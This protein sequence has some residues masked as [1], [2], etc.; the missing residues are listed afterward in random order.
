[1]LIALWVAL[2][3]TLTA[4]AYS[5]TWDLFI[6]EVEYLEAWLEGPE[7]RD[8]GGGG[9]R[10]TAAADLIERS[11]KKARSARATYRFFRTSRNMSARALCV[12]GD[13]VGGLA[14]GAQRPFPQGE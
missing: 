13:G 10:V 11:G 14:L 8:E 2:I 7:H 4:A 9:T 3:V 6:G 1:V 5:V 12:A